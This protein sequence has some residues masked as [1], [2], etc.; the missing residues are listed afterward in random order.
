MDFLSDTSNASA[1]DVISFVREVVEKF[2]E[3]RDGIVDKLLGAMGDIKSGKVYRGA[4]WILGEYV[5]GRDG[6]ERT[7]AGVREVLGEV[8]ILAAEQVR[9]YLTHS[10][11]VTD[12][13]HCSDCWTRPRQLQ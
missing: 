2:P 6:I 8:P 4:L 9:R 11:A 7:L 10:Y 1:V 5:G 3:L 13:I 12:T